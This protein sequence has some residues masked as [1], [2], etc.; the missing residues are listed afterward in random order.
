MF[1]IDVI[2][3][4]LQSSQTPCVFPAWLGP[5]SQP[6]H[7]PVVVTVAFAQ[8][9]DGQQGEL[10]RPAR[11]LGSHTPGTAEYWAYQLFISVADILSLRK[12]SDD[13]C[14][15]VVSRV[16]AGAA[17]GSAVSLGYEKWVAA[18]KPCLRQNCG[19]SRADHIPSDA[20]DCDRCRPCPNH[21]AWSCTT[22]TSRASNARRSPKSWSSQRGP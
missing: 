18:G 8:H 4:H 19:H 6:V 3:D 17:Q 9:R 20:M 10:N 13:A 12:G 15:S 16:D 1:G 5:P 7:R 2:D 11:R 21:F 22:P 14:R